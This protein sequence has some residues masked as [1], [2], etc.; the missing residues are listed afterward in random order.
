MEH[1]E[2][3]REVERRLRDFGITDF[4]NEIIYRLSTKTY[5][6]IME[7]RSDPEFKK[8]FLI[9]LGNLHNEIDGFLNF[10]KNK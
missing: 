5:S 6:E 3:R 7:M 1:H 9:A 2:E 8:D 4:A 10:V